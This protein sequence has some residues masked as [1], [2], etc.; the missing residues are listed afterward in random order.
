MSDKVDRVAVIGGGLI[1]ASWAALFVAQ[2]LSVSVY[3]PRAD[4]EKGIRRQIDM[5]WPDLQAVGLAH[6]TLNAAQSRLMVSSDLAPVL[7]GVGFV[8]ECGPDRLE[9]KQQIIAEIERHLPTDVVIASSSSALMASEIQNGASHPERILIGHPFNPP[10]L[11]PLVELVAGRAT[12]PEAIKAAHRFYIRLGRNVIIPKKEVRGHLANR[13]TAALYREAVHLVAEGIATVEDVDRA[14]TA[15]PGLRWSLM[16][17][18]LTYHLGGGAGGLRDYLTHLGPAQEA[19]WADLG[20]P[21]LDAATVD[22]LVSG[23]DKAL[24][25]QDAAELAA[26][27]DRALVGLLQVKRNTGLD[28]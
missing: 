1:G 18:H 10:H 14:I 5:A 7:Q 4:A 16:G 20:Q 8:Q 17:P 21:R 2:G 3:E 12:S 22:A 27:R 24:K 25:D 26:K 13:L 11:I 19:R 6:D 9:L 23:M 15:G 28:G